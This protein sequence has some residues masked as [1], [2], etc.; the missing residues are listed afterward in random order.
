M[1]VEP[2][3]RTS[4]VV[5][6]ELPAEI[7]NEIYS[8]L[9]PLHA[10]SDICEG[11][12]LSCKQV[13]SEYTRLAVLL[14]S[15]LVKKVLAECKADEKDP[16]PEG[17]NWLHWQQMDVSIPGTFKELTSLT[18]QLP[19]SLRHR[20]YWSTKSIHYDI[21]YHYRRP[22]NRLYSLHLSQIEIKI[23]D[24]HPIERKDFSGKY[25]PTQVYHA[26]AK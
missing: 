20:S 19:A 18:V 7:R 1:S 10:Y 23:R 13:S 8:Y 6:L 3:G 11:L 15:K 5:F 16:P 22:L 21:S 17:G 24:D 4:D 14:V 25:T 9:T 26:L 12:V 2:T